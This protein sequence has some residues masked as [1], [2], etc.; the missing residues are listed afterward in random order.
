MKRE[1]LVAEIIKFRPSADLLEYLKKIYGELY[2]NEEW[3]RN[4]LLSLPN[5]TLHII[6][7][8]LRYV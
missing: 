6:W 2:I 5:L 4:K 8:K 1:E 7:R 3:D